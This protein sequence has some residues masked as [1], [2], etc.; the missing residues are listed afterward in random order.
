MFP[1]RSFL[2]IGDRV[3]NLSLLALFGQVLA[4]IKVNDYKGAICGLGRILTAVTCGTQAELLQNARPRE[5]IDAEHFADPNRNPLPPDPLPMSA[6]ELYAETERFCAEL[7][8]HAGHN[9]EIV[10]RGDAS[11]TELT[12]GQWLALAELVVNILRRFVKKPKDWKPT[13]IETPPVNLSNFVGDSAAPQSSLPTMRRPAD[14]PGVP[15][16][17]AQTDP[18]RDHVNTEPT[19]NPPPG[20]P[21]HPPGKP[22]DEKGVFGSE[23]ANTEPTTTLPPDALKNLPADQPPG[24][25]AAGEVSNESGGKVSDNDGF[26]DGITP[27]EAGAHPDKSHGKEK[28]N[29]PKGGKH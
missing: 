19:T 11:D 8:S 22:K 3:M 21:A 15:P 12:P 7:E 23:I 26:G 17:R 25:P 5:E 28:G 4:A 18:I 20:A 27:K 6:G 10:R 1:R 29:K 9:E 13:P 24:S 16:Q 2:L 14:V